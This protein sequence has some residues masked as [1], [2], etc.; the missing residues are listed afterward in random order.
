[1]LRSEYRIEYV[2]GT[3][4]KR[5]I[6]SRPAYLYMEWAYYLSYYLCTLIMTDKRAWL[7]I[8]L[9]RLHITRHLVLIVVVVVI[10]TTVVVISVRYSVVSLSES[11]VEGNIYVG[12]PFVYV[13]L[14]LIFIVIV[15]VIMIFIIIICKYD[16]YNYCMCKY[17]IYNY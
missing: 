9:I 7:H 11:V 17:G 16:I 3:L 6:I 15:G 13:F 14:L 10:F 1:M 2:L 12:G 5:H 8:I 4:W